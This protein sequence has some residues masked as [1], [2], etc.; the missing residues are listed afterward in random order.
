[1]RIYLDSKDLINVVEHANP[2]SLAELSERLNTHTAKLV[3]SFS[4]VTELVA[5]LAYNGDTLKVRQWLNDLETVTPHYLAE[6]SIQVSELRSAIDAYNTKTEYTAIDPYV[7]RFDFTLRSVAKPD[8]VNYRLSDIVLDIWRH[9]HDWFEIPIRYARSL[10][11]ILGADRQIPNSRR[12]AKLGAHFGNV[13][14]RYMAQGGIAIPEDLSRIASWVYD[15]PRR[16]PGLRLSY[17]VFHQLA[18]DPLDAVKDSDLLDIAQMLVIPYVDAMTVDR[19]MFH[20]FKGA[21]R[22][23]KQGDRSIRYADYVYSRVEDL[24]AATLQ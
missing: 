21:A 9:Q 15:L 17:E 2:L 8:I 22:K 11:A 1:V 12:R 7:R 18:F 24:I 14:S 4:S 20:Y 13:I 3:L 23:L 16:C 5:P 6:S 19:R 10:R